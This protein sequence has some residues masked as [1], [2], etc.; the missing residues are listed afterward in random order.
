MAMMFVI[1]RL[2]GVIQPRYLIAVGAAIA[3]FSMYD[4]TNVYGD[5]G[6]WFLAHSRMYLGI[7]R[8]LTFVPI[9]TASY[10]GIPPRRPPKLP[11]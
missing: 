4:L 1:G 8:P 9:M 10:E 2:F 11:R 7:G 3:A 6:V 5:L